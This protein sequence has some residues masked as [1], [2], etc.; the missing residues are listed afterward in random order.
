MTMRRAHA[1]GKVV[2]SGE[3]AVLFGAP[4]VSMA[5]DRRAAVSHGNAA[6]RGDS[7]LLDTVCATLGIAVPESPLK[8]DTDGFR[9][10]HSGTKYGIGSSAALTVAL[11]AFLSD[12]ADSEDDIVGLAQAAHRSFQD[13]KGSGVDIATSTDGGVILFRMNSADSEALLW[14]DGLMYSLFWSGTAADTTTR[15]AALDDTT[16]TAL[17]RAAESTARAWQSGDAENVMD[18]YREYLPVLAEFDAEHG[19]GIFAAGHDSIG[20]LAEPLDVIY[21]PCGA[22]GGDVGIALATDAESLSLFEHAAESAGFRRLDMSI[23][24]RGVAVEGDSL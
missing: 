4:A 7:K 12:D 18:S 15:L 11:V 6:T 9:D 3:Y 10:D 19:L 5:V 8:L 23:D 21:K 1:P 14:P 13:G 16:P 22:G 24:W 17:S 2:L 20:A